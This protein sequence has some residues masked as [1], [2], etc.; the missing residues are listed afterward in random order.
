TAIALE[1][2]G[3]L[4]IFKNAINATVPVGFAP[5]GAAPVYS[6]NQS[7][8]YPKGAYYFVVDN[9]NGSV[10]AN[11]KLQASIIYLPPLSNSSITSGPFAGLSNQINQE[12]IFGFLFFVLLVAGVIVIIY[13]FIKK[14]KG[15]AVAAPV[16]GKLQKEDKNIDQSYVDKLYKDVEKR[17]KAK[18]NQR[19][20][21]V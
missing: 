21:S 11:N 18:K 20:G 7:S 10:S 14:P 19:K 15:E 5:I 16:Y 6:T 12:L 4:Y 13:G 17:K 1:N 3:A 9:T 2:K 8:I